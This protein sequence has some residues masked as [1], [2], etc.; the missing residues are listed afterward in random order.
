MRKQARKEIV[1]LAETKRALVVNEN[2]NYA[3][4]LAAGS[5][6]DD[7]VIANV[8]SFINIGSQ[9]FQY[10]G[11]QITDPMVVLKLGVTV[12]WQ[13]LATQAPT[14]VPEV[15]VDAYLIAVNDQIASTLT[16]RLTTQTE[17]TT[18][19]MKPPSN[20]NRVPWTHVINGQAVLVLKKRSVIL[21]HPNNPAGMTTKNIT[22]KKRFRGHKTYETVFDSNGGETQSTYL[23]GWNFYWLVATV[24]NAAFTAA[25]V[26]S[27]PIS[28]VGDRY[29]YFKDF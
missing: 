1:K 10:T 29:V 16:P 2:W 7:T 23:R 11:N 3:G 6:F 19:W 15:R 8:F 13:A 24:P 25:A 27:N 12:Q 28:V 14:F 26:T 9:D 18:I 21:H 22:L 17:D 5:T 4:A 20:G